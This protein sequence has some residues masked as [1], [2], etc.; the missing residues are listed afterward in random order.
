LRLVRAA[1]L[2]VG[3][4]ALGAACEDKGDKPVLP[5]EPKLGATLT[6][7]LAGAAGGF[8][9]VRGKLTKEPFGKDGDREWTSSVT[10]WGS[11]PCT[12]AKRADGTHFLACDVP[13]GKGKDD[14]LLR[15][16]Y[17][18]I[19]RQLQAALP[20]ARFKERKPSM[21]GCERQV[22]GWEDRDRGLVLYV[23]ADSSRCG[24]PN[25]LSLVVAQM[26]PEELAAAR[27]KAKGRFGALSSTDAGVAEAKS[28]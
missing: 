17:D 13:M 12:V 14:P 27:E 7:L 16:R 5:A 9:S 23:Y 24:K 10:L 21:V 4:V 26:R 22:F 28:D 8:E 1:L 11:R 6:E 3:V 15:R 2:L 20:E 19:K 18:E 25:H